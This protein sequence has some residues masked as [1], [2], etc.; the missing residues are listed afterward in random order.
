ML[1]DFSFQ[2]LCFTSVQ[3]TAIVPP[4]W[5]ENLSKRSHFSKVSKFTFA[6]TLRI[7]QG[8]QTKK[9][10]PWSLQKIIFWNWSAADMRR[11]CKLRGWAKSI[12]NDGS[13]HMW[14]AKSQGKWL[15]T[16]Y[17]DSK[18]QRPSELSASGQSCIYVSFPII[19][20]RRRIF[21]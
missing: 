2:I 15:L 9:K 4:L 5:V 6:R 17:G 10:Y 21:K 20:D 14:M 1:G 12:R 8:A 16:P 13:N 18:V 7:N 11:L 19:L 3:I